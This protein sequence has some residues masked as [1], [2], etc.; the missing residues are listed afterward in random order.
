M[1]LENAY[2]LDIAL[3]VVSTLRVL[4]CSERDKETD[5]DKKRKLQEEIDMMYFERNALYKTG[6]MQRSIMDKA[7]K[8]Y[9]P[10]VK[11]HYAAV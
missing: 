2:D 5:P 11:A 3:D 4:K 1:L 8:L 7:F 10:I 6:E 9:A